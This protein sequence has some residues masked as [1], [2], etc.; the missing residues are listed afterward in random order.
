[1]AARKKQGEE[2]KKQWGSTHHQCPLKTSNRS[3]HRSQCVLRA[4]AH[5]WVC[6]TRRAEPPHECSIEADSGLVQLLDRTRQSLPRPLL[7]A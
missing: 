7:P 2:C 1:M 6:H 5:A 4:V 3:M